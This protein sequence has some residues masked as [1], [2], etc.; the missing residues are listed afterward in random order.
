MRAFLGIYIVAALLTS[1]P[2]LVLGAE[3]GV[4]GT[5]RQGT[6]TLAPSGTFS[7]TF[8]GP[9]GGVIGPTGGGAVAELTENECTKLGCE[10]K[11]DNSCSAVVIGEP[12]KISTVKKRCA[13]A[14]GSSCI[15]EAKE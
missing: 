11:D 10:V 15:T 13:C 12:F 3:K 1:G 7:G 8:V 6:T 4:S 9:S 5:F 2:I 14:S